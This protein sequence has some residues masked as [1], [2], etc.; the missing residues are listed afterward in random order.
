METIKITQDVELS[1]I[2][3]GLWRLKNWNFETIN[4]VNFMHRCIELG[5]TT[6]DTAEIYGD[7]GVE[8]EIGKALLWDPSLRQKIQ[9]VT[10]TG[11]N[12]KSPV[13]SYK[14]GHYDTRYEKIVASCKES[15]A[16]M[17]CGYLDL[18]LIH[19]EDPL[20]D[21]DEVARALHDLKEA[22]L[23]KAY[24]VSNFD[25]FKFEALQKATGDRLATNQI[26]VS[27]VCF[28][29]F[30]SG[31]MDVLQKH[32]VHPM[33]WSPLAGGLLF[34]SNDPMYVKVRRKLEEIADRH[35]STPETI[36]YAWLLYHPV[37]MMPIS[38]S[39]S[40]ERL[41]AACNAFDVK[42]SHEEWYEIYIASGQQHLR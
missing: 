33:I 14:I 25:P 32:H 22:G 5:V 40:L 24:G 12:M 7:Y 13:R 28:E 18:F 41:S 8:E 39:S 35:R 11:I 31:L 3:Q 21:H 16:K 1:R 42:L 36:A 34:T 26:E 10:K 19:R 4:T 30:D 2:I 6:F 9:L 23:I 29:H 37:K 38:G 27:P 20:I 15:I 17:N